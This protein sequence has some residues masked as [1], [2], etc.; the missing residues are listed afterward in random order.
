MTVKTS[1]P[2][3]DR[4]ACLMR[5]DGKCTALTDNKKYEGKDCPFLCAKQRYMDDI[6]YCLERKKILNRR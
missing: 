1:E 5:K 6:R 2:D 3:C 4:V